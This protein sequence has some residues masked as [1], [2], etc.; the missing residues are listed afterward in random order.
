[1]EKLTVGGAPA[2]A[3][4]HLGLAS[5][6]L[7]RF[8]PGLAEQICRMMADGKSGTEIHRYLTTECGYTLTL[9]RLNQ[10]LAQ[11]RKARAPI[12]KAIVREKLETSVGSDLESLSTMKQQL[13]DMAEKAMKKGDTSMYLKIVDRIKALIDVRMHYA[14]AD[15]DR[16]KE[17]VS[18]AAER[19]AKKISSLMATPPV[20]DVSVD[21]QP[22]P[23]GGDE[24]G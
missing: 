16:S 9:R 24:P 1:M 3:Y 11:E 8:P 4:A 23:T 18:G 6:A 22:S 13:E 15:D 21:S 14:G 2:S 10:I 17:D 5:K 19:V 12:A 7:M 20:K